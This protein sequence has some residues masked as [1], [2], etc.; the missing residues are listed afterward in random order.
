[1]D[2]E[3][4]VRKITPRRRRARKRGVW[5]LVQPGLQPSGYLETTP[6][7]IIL[8]ANRPMAALLRTTPARLVGKPLS[9]FVEE[10]GQHRLRGWLRELSATGRLE[11][12]FLSLKLPR[13]RL[14][15]AEVT[16]AVERGLGGKTE[17]FRW[18]VCEALGGEGIAEVR[19]FLASIVL[20]S[21]DAIISATADG[22]VTMW[23]PA[24]E[25]LLGY[26]TDEI[27]GDRVG[28][29]VPPHRQG[30]IKR[31]F[32]GILRGER[33][34]SFETER[35]HKD[36]T[37][38]P[39]SLTAFPTINFRGALVG[40][41]A[42][43]RDITERKRLEQTILEIGER[44]HRQ[45]GQ[46]LHDGLCQ[47]LLGVN[48]LGRALENRLSRSRPEEA[49]MQ[50]INDY[51]EKLLKDVRGVA[52]GLHP[53]KAEPN[54]LMSAL[55]ELAEHIRNIFG[56]PCRFI[57]PRPVLISREEVATH[58]Y[59]IAQE[60][61]RNALQ[62]G[63]PSHIWIRL[64]RK[65]GA[66][67]LCVRSDGKRFGQPPRGHKGIGLEIMRYRAGVMGAQLKVQ[68]G[69]RYGTEVRCVLPLAPRTR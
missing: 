30:E 54:G 65:A 3:E 1:M 31:I 40:F 32:S 56:V 29:L 5:P 50:E 64:G 10:R 2:I 28:R 61:T 16:V 8:E 23:N 12:G 63:K 62:H 24:A 47:Q 37:I 20:S 59:R 6:A 21:L 13:G 46:E 49:A 17:C 33:Y 48:Y 25:K 68:R 51:L 19:S 58:L 66:I 67:V 53:V 45:I 22:M 9:R 42:V 14:F 7:G 55:E 35:M 57:C 18:R 43:L 69:A 4:T 34:Q 39:V 27:I 44:E 36:G 52:R 41:T 15:P 38:I 26:T 11:E 60:A